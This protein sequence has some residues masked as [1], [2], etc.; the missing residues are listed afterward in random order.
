VPGRRRAWGKPR[1]SYDY[2]DVIAGQGTATLEL[3]EEAGLLDAL[4][5]CLGSGGLLAGA[6]CQKA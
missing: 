6:A 3:I 2:P 4:Y 1:P 5:V